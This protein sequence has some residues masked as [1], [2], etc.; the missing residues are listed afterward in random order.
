MLAVY[1][2][3]AII[4]GGLAIA[5]AFGGDHD[6][7]GDHEFGHDHGGDVDH[8]GGF[9]DWLPF[10]SLRFWTYFAF[11][12]GASGLLLTY[13]A[14]AGEPLTMGLSLGTAFVL[15]T[16]VSV[17][18]KALQKLSGPNVSE[19][20]LRGLVGKVLVPIR[21]GETGKIRAMQFGETIDFLALSEESNPIEAGEEVVI[22]SFDNN[23]ALVMRASELTE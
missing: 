19:A 1:I 20:D 12:L 9:A 16:L 23:R 17:G 21:P 13:V 8:G 22:V 18:M 14:K 15:G 6:H 10:F 2:V 3:S 7:P 5:S 11:A 4:G